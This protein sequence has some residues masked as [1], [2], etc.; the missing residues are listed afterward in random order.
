MERG[1]GSNFIG[2]VWNVKVS[3]VLGGLLAQPVLLSGKL[4]SCRAQIQMRLD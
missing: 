3:F 4:E 1:E 2:R